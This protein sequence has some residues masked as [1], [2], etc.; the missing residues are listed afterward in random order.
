MAITFQI[1]NGDVLINTSTGRPKLIGNDITINENSTSKASMKVSQDLRGG[2][3]T[4]RI[5][6]GAG[7]GI[8]EL[9]GLVPSLGTGFISISLNK[10]IRDMFSSIL[11]LQ[12][13][14]VNSRPPSEKLSKIVAFIIIPGVDQ[15]SFK[16]KLDAITISGETITQSGT[17]IV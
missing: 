17:I 9:V 2:L 3:S 5:R 14:N 1:N 6:S 4:N 8:N 16:F 11:R 13:L 15:T 12:K 7:A 10:Q